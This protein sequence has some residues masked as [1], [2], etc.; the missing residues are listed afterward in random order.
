MRWYEVLIAVTLHG[1]RLL[2]IV[3]CLLEAMTMHRLNQEAKTSSEART[4]ALW[5]LL[6]LAQAVVILVYTEP[7]P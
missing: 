2:Y 5:T 7:T 3:F 6:F 1:L 4:Y